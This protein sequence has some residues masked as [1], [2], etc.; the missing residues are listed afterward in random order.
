MDFVPTPSGQLDSDTLVQ[1]VS[2][3]REHRAV[4]VL[5]QSMSQED[6]QLR[7][8]SPHAVV[9]DGVRWHARV[10]CHLQH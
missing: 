1:L 8:V 4:S 5:H 7:D 3:I 2:A 9:H 6:P 10:Y